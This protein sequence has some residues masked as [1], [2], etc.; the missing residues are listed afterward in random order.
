MIELGHPLDGDK[1]EGNCSRGKDK[2]E[3]APCDRPRHRQNILVMIKVEADASNRPVVSASP[4]LPGVDLTGDG[5]LGY[6]FTSADEL[7]E[8]DIGPGD[9]PRPTF[10]SKKLDPQLRGQMIALLKEYPDCFAWDYTEMPGLDRSII[11]H[12]LPLKKGF[13]PFQQRA[14]QMRAEIL[15][16]VKKE[17]EKML[18]AGFIRPCRY[19]EWISSIVPVEKK[20]GRW[21][22]AIDFRDLNRATPK[23][24]YP[25]RPRL[26]S[27]HGLLGFNG[28]L[29]NG[30]HVGYT[31]PN[32]AEALL[33]KHTEGENGI[34]TDTICLS[35]L[36]LVILV[37]TRHQLIAQGTDFSQIGLQIGCEACHPRP[38]PSPADCSGSANNFPLQAEETSSGDVEEIQM[39]SATL[40]LATSAVAAA[41]MVNPPQSTEK[42]IVTASAVPPSLGEGCDLSSLLT[43]DPESIEPTSSKAS[44]E[45]IPSTVRGPLQRLK[46]LLSAP[47]ETLI[48][49]SEEAKGILEDIQ[50]HLPMTCK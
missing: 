38:Y 22:V 1:G 24:E 13:R 26:F 34:D 40:D 33:K 32:G 4:A 39:P 23:D 49:D 37:L 11:E 41:Q 5:K 9:K 42:P 45:P 46:D 20:D 35:D 50:L 6:G 36:S 16:E 19:A 48:E 7:E 18:A 14:R 17:I 21:R 44:G 12:R 8:V 43:F 28:D 25:S 3:A 47:T 10:I 15:E 27:L 29:T 2:E 30:G 31:N